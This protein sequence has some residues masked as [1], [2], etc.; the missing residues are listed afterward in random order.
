M[1]EGLLLA[2]I[3]GI[4]AALGEV[5]GFPVGLPDV[6]ELV[7]VETRPHHD[8][9]HLQ[10]LMVL[11]VEIPLLSTCILAEE[12]DV[13]SSLDPLLWLLLLLSGGQ[14]TDAHPLLIDP[15]HSSD[16]APHLNYSQLQKD[17]NYM[18]EGRP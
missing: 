2:D 15:L 16:P 4:G 3:F 12:V 9:A 11:L 7:L 17:G 5:V 18:L 10:V 13:H 8:A 14:Q 6:F 1:D